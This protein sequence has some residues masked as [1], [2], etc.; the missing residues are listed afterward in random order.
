M[1]EVFTMADALVAAQQKPT[2]TSFRT[3]V[4]ISTAHWVSHLYM[5]AL[6]MMFPFLKT[7]LG[8]SYIELGFALTVSGITSF[9]AQAPIGYLCDRIGSLRVLLAGLV[10]GGLALI[11]LSLHLSY[12]WLIGSAVLLGLANSVYHPA[13]Y[14]ILAANIDQSRMGRAFSI[15]TFAGY[16]GTAVAPFFM[17][18][19][20][21]ATGGYSALI[22]TGMV[23]PAAALL[24][25]G[26]AIP[27]ARAEVEIVDG[28]RQARATILSPALILLTVFFL[29]LSLSING[30]NNFGI[31]ALMSGYGAP[32]STASIALT[33]FLTASAIGVL[34]GGLLADRT[35]SHG[36]FAAACFA[37]NAILVLILA[38]ASMPPA[39]LIT[40][41][42][43]A[44]FL[45]GVI[46]PS[47]DMLV[48]NAA[49]PGA[50]GRAFGIVSTGFNLGNILSPVLFGWIMDR[51]LPHWVFG[52][53]AVF[54]V[55]TVVL[56]LI[57]DRHPGRLRH[58]QT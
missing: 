48:H 22:V 55:V 11:L 21:A 23:G 9:V 27:D 15:H 28:K 51:Q 56:A 20:T 5:Y 18:G 47:R 25:V 34:A 31:V 4:G 43:A 53:S 14:A 46:A 8:A 37:L 30:I 40:I 35:R 24:L 38:L 33:A 17:A 49:P 7:E 16:A 19:L 6:A 2:N 13:D 32:F 36:Q 57:T 45:S 29:L 44:G 58:V 1:K 12:P 10:L 26:L 3:L 39:M 41:M 42:I 50:S 54:M 52:M